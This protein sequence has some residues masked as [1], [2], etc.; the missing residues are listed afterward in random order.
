MRLHSFFAA[1]L[2]VALVACSAELPAPEVFTVQPN[3]AFNG[4]DTLVTIGG[5]AFYPQVEVDAVQTGEGDINAGFAARLVSGSET[6]AELVSTGL[7]DFEHLQAVVPAGVEPGLYAIE[8]QSPA[9][10][11]GRLDGAF[12][13][14]NT[15]ADH[16]DVDVDLLVYEVFDTA[17]VD[18]AVV[19]GNDARVL[20]DLPI[21]LVVQGEGGAVL[22]GFEPTGMEQVEVDLDASAVRG[23]LGLDGRARI[24]VQVGT[25]GTTTIK[26]RTT[27]D[28]AGVADGEVRLL[29][30]PGSELSLDIEL[31]ED[32]F[33]ATAGVPFTAELSL[34]DQFGNPVYGET[35][36]VLLRNR[37]E[38]WVDAVSVSGVTPVS[39]TLREATGTAACDTD[40]L[41]SVSGPS[42]E[43]ER[44]EVRAGAVDHFD[45]VVNPSEVVAGAGV[46]NIFVT[47]VDRYG[48]LAAGAGTSLTLTE[49][50][51]ELLN[52]SCVGTTPIFCTATPLKAGGELVLSVVDT[53]GTAGSSNPHTVLAAE[54]QTLSAAFDATA[55]TAGEAALLRVDA[56]DAYGN[57]AVVAGE[58]QVTVDGAAVPCEARE[59]DDEGRAVLAC[60]F[61]EATDSLVASV[62]VDALTTQTDA[63]RVDNGPL[64]LAEVSLGSA[65]VGA[66][67]PVTV[68]LR[69]T[70]AWGNPYLVQDD[71]VVELYDDT[72]TLSV[73]SVALGGTGEASLVASVTAAGSTVVH[74]AQGGEELGA[75]E[76]LQ[77][78]PGAAADLVIVAS[79]PWAF[80]GDEVTLRVEARDAWGNP[81]P[82][83]AVATLSST[84]DDPVELSLSTGSASVVRVYASSLTDALGAEADGLGS[85]TRELVVARDCGEGSPIPAIAFG[86]ESTAIACADADEQAVVSVSLAGSTGSQPVAR[87][88]VAL[89]NEPVDA[90][91][92]AQLALDGIGR[93]AVSA[94]VVDTAGCGAQ[95]TAE[96]WV[97]LPDG[98]P[99]GPLQLATSAAVLPVATG[100]AVLTVDDVRDCAGD[101]AAGETLFA[102]VDR[103]ELPGLTATGAG[104]SVTTDTAGDAAFTLD[105][106]DVRSG[107]PA[108]VWL[109]TANGSAAASVPL[110]VSGD[111][112]KPQVVRVAPSG[113]L[114][115]ATDRLTVEL[116]EPM[117][118]SSVVPGAFRIDGPVSIGIAEA[119]LASDAR[120]VELVL[121]TPVDPAD[122]TFSAVVT[123]EL[124]DLTGNRLD[125]TYTGESYDFAVQLGAVPAPADGPEACSVDRERFRPDGDDGPE[126][127]A[128]GASLLWSASAASGERL[129]EV[130][131]ADGNRVRA[132]VLVSASLGQ[133]WW[134]DGRDDSGRVVPDGLY[135]LQV[136]LRDEHG[137]EVYGC[138]AD[139]RV[140]NGA[141]RER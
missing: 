35:E 80:V 27:S 116:T 92:G 39:V 72:G 77:V 46:L 52:A 67:E 17:W 111:L 15:R 84:V 139:T 48:N 79:S 96:A 108:R 24:G 112:K 45:V 54:A 53:L 135:T 121:A 38:T 58:A 65:S 99:T 141:R 63:V 90:L 100:T 28:D 76:P 89:G 138:A 34:R 123:R 14:T 87:G 21:E 6:V 83:E 62:A 75:S 140:D 102:R 56:R 8:V 23:N 1:L 11:I 32:D 64:A 124:R 106:S 109:T 10:R 133:S 130:L 5:R 86:E 16:L 113:L 93:H 110:L 37:C 42:G 127:E 22:A 125:G 122:G 18:I 49:S 97:G 105:L 107:G 103:G 47:P 85:A 2:P 55:L 44:V 69:G 66:G 91:S 78:V 60:T 119:T 68:A 51:G 126:D 33:V 50:N 94:F 59:S 25:P 36:V 128:D 7:I 71:A 82:T 81:S 12:T 20:S 9:G 131:T 57:A 88:L 40:A 31:P 129:L 95:R 61:T 114:A 117:L 120:F 41:L 73:D 132:D 30:E 13:V 137:N 70:D 4:E 115:A 29:W 19:D 136:S 26:V 134:W 104:L 118:A 98:S 74:V 3:T 101:V 43:S